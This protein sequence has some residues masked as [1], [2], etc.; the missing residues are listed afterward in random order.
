MSR[1]PTSLR[2][3]APGHCAFTVAGRSLPGHLDLLFRFGVQASVLPPYSSKDVRVARCEEVEAPNIFSALEASSGTC[4]VW[5]STH[6]H[7]SAHLDCKTCLRICQSRG[8]IS[9][10]P[11]CAL[12]PE[13]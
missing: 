4:K 9:L 12:S 13:L 2:H 10:S 5:W 3:T 6:E 1:P 11:S 7:S 8:Y